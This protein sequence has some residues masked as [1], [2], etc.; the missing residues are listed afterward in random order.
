MSIFLRR[1][2]QKK[3][4]EQ[5]VDVKDHASVRGQANGSKETNGPNY[6]MN[7]ELE[8]TPPKESVYQRHFPRERSLEHTSAV[9]AD[10]ADIRLRAYFLW[11]ERNASRGS[12]EDDWFRARK[13]LQQ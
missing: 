12:S 1:D 3:E 6:E 10:E 4:T 11:E 7:N 2:L 9:E 13:E 8:L 5:D